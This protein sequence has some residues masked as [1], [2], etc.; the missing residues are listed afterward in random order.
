MDFSY[1]YTS[2]HTVAPSRYDAK[3]GAWH[4]WTPL[5]AL[6]LVVLLCAPPWWP[7]WALMWSLAAAV[8][9]GCKWL[10]WSQAPVVHVPW[11]QNA[12]Y[13]LAWPGLDASA[14]LMT[15]QLAHPRR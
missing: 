11:W 6:P 1:P 3:R 13:L 2:S 9:A 5:V 7:S 10:T 12:G 14:F 4:A 15:R 8:F